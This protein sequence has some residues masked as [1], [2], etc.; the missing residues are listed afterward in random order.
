[1]GIDVKRREE[2]RWSARID[3]E[4]DYCHGAYAALQS[5]LWNAMREINA[6]IS[7]LIRADPRD[8]KEDPTP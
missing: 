7:E 6:A 3:L 5:L 2:G 8:A 4:V 1:M